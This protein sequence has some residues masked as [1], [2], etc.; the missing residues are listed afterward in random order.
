MAKR[1]AHSFRPAALW[2]D[3][4]RN[5][6]VTLERNVL[7]LGEARKNPVLASM[8]GEARSLLAIS[9][10]PHAVVIKLACGFIA[11]QPDASGRS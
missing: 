3:P 1:G 6:G 9:W 2:G 11:K 8:L 7:R 4:T 5:G 10:Q